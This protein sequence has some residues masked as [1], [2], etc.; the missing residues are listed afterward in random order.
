MNNLTLNKNEMKKKLGQSFDDDRMDRNRWRDFAIFTNRKHNLKQTTAILIFTRSAEAEIRH[1]NFIEGASAKSNKKI[2]R[3]LI[4]QTVCTASK[5]LS[6]VFT[7]DETQQ[8]GE[9]FGEKFAN[10]FQKLFDQ[11][12]E[13]VIAIGNDCPDLTAETLKKTID[14]LQ[15]KQVV[16][17]PSK[18]EGMYLIGLS[19]KGFSFDDFSN[20]PWQ[21]KGLLTEFIRQTENTNQSILLLSELIDLDNFNDVKS[22]IRKGKI[23]GYFKKLLLRLIQF[24]TRVYRTFFFPLQDSLQ[25]EI[26]VLRGP[27]ATIFSV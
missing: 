19:K 3:T 17:G 6:P 22:F 27:P 7:I 26:L 14:E 15:R 4:Q 18:D 25:G 1:K 13:K 16:V 5:T 20:L 2:V 24:L 11:G 8:I 12:F 10:S 23:S 21:K 9:T